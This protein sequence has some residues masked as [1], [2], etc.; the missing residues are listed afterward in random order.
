MACRD[1]TELALSD[2]HIIFM[3]G[4][5]VPG[6]HNKVPTAVAPAAQMYGLTGRW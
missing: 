2:V 1:S 4:V 3:D 5:S 6:C